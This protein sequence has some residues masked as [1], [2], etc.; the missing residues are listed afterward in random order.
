MGIEEAKAMIKDLS[1]EE[2]RRVALYILELE[3]ENVQKTIGPQ[4]SEDLK[5]FSRVVQESIEKLKK[6]VGKM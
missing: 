3:K 6:A 5:A 4:I 1:V 2:R